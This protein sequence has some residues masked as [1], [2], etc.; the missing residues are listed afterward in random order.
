MK[1][2]T[3]SAGPA[4]TLFETDAYDFSQTNNWDVGPDGRF[5]MIKSDPWMLRQIQVVQ[6]F[7]EELRERL[8]D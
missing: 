1:S 4:N 7:P 6:N 5:V 3:R 8:P 2:S